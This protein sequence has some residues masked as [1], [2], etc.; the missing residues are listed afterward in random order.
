MSVVLRALIAAVLASPF[1][2]APIRSGGASPAAA[3]R[4]KECRRFA[5]A[6]RVH[7]LEDHAYT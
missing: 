2:L 6:G 1:A 5:P 4:A 7:L 3:P